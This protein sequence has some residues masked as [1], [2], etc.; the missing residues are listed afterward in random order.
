M[1]IASALVL[2]ASLFVV[3][4]GAVGQCTCSAGHCDQRGCAD[5]ASCGGGHCNQ[6]DLVFPSCGAG[7]CDQ[8]NTTNP[9]CGGGHC[10]QEN[11][12]NPTCN[13]GHCCQRGTTNATCAAGH[14]NC[15]LVC[16]G[17]STPLF[18][19]TTGAVVAAR[20]VSIGEQIR[21]VSTED[22]EDVC[23]DVYYVFAHEEPGVSVRITSGRDDAFTVS[24]DHIVYVGDTFENRRPVLSQDVVPGDKLVVS[25]SHSN[26]VEVITVEIAGTEDLVN[27]LTLDPH[28]QVKSNGDGS[29]I[30]SAHSV[31]DA[32]YRALFAPVRFVYLTF[33]ATAVKYMK[34]LFNA[35]DHSLAKP[36]LRMLKW[37]TTAQ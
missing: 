24:Y 7:H 23:S 18:S 5:G 37:W 29:I 36:G 14:C 31:D 3:V 25:T 22:G 20:D 34:P 17:G 6:Q 28:L 19:C 16:V 15:N 33:G 4:P 26:P 1:K 9:T 12:L 27:V 11:A 35:I 32:A 21:A 10:N 13:A 30:I 8:R 2:C